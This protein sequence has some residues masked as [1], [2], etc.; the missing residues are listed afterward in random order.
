MRFLLV[1]LITVLGADWS[2]AQPVHGIA[3]HGEP[4][5]PADFKH[6]SYVNPEVKKGGRVTYGVV[7]TFDSFNPFILKSMRTTAR[8]MWDPGFGN[9]VYESLMQRSSDEAFTLYGL[10]AETVEWDDARSYIQFN[11]NP[12]AKWADGVP[13]T[14]EDVI[15]SFELLRDKGRVPYSS[16]MDRIAKLEKVGERSVRVTFNDKSNREFPLILA[17]GM[18]ILP[19][20]LIKSETFDQSSLELPIGSGPYKVKSVSPGERIVY[21]RDPNY[22]GKDIPAKV[23]FDNYDEISIE[24]FLQ[25]NTLFEAFKKGAIDI[26]PEGSPSHWTRAYDFP[27]MRS[28]DI[29]KDVFVPKLPTGMLGFVFNTRREVFANEKL[30]AGLSLVFDFE[31]ANRTLFEGAYK[32][33]QSLWQNSVLSGTGENSAA[34]ERELALLGKARSRIEPSVLDGTYA[35]PVSDGS[36]ADR[37]ILRQAVDLMQQAGYTIR[38]GKMVDA[39]GRP[40]VFEIMSQTIDQEKLAIAYQRS[41]RTIGVEVSIRTVDDAQYQSRSGNFDYDMIVKS[42]PASLSPGAEQQGRWGSVSRD[43]NGSFNYAGT[44]DPDIDRIINAMLNA[45]S[46]EDFE[47]AVRVYDKLLVSGHYMV[48]LYHIGEQWVARRSYIG[49][50]DKVPLY[51]YQL[52][53]WW[54]ARVQ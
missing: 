51:G 28:G 18:P 46:E 38:N 40:L 3:M 4:A 33:T 32:R 9:F 45:R 21:Q 44:A 43:R 16:Y 24:Y 54:D 41:L 39:K 25:D 49:H 30:R 5:L 23:G 17:A 53:T 19:K 50:P 10:L 11:L 22:W 15:F 37:K 13:V 12:K 36:G 47:A 2:W 42:Y 52:A 14:S 27:A 34:G 26:Y 6:F 1:C 29:V 35:L 48:P 31:W 8:G 7:G 20:H